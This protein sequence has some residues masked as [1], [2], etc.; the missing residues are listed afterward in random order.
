MKPPRS[1]PVPRFKSDADERRYYGAM[2][3][4]AA[5]HGKANLAQA[6]LLATR[7]CPEGCGCNGC[8]RTRRDVEE[9]KEIRRR[10]APRAAA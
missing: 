8:E 3:E 5:E 10:R 9:A 2:A 1:S 6:Y 4:L 7:D